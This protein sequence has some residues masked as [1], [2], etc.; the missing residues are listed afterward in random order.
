MNQL[1]SADLAIGQS[2][3]ET[4]RIVI[5]TLFARITS[6]DYPPDSR[7]PSER[8]LAT[9]LSVSRNTVREALDVLETR[10]IIRRRQGSGSFVIYQSERPEPPRRQSLGDRTSPLDHLIVRSI[11]EPEMFRLAVMNMTPLE[12]EELS[13][14]VAQIEAV[15]TDVTEFVRCEEEFYR[16]IA[17]ATRNALLESCY[18]LTIEVCRQSFR[19]ALMRKHLTP[20]RIQDYQ[21][22]FNSLFN[23]I[24]TRDVE[25]AVEIVKLHLVEEQKLFLHDR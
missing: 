2:V 17:R 21:T 5:D 15:R 19:T 10:K 24:A 22:R 23:A 11:I 20:D 7:L 6:G 14:T 16:R 18:E 4:V 25:A 13:R 3:G 1:T 9:E 12:L 8:A